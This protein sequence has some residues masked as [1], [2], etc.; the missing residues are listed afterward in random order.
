MNPFDNDEDNNVS[1]NVFSNQI[2][3]WIITTGRKSNTFVSGW[4][5]SDDQLKEHLKNIKKKNGCNGSIKD[6]LDENT[7]NTIKTLQLQG[8][9]IDF[10][11]DYLINNGVDNNTIYVKG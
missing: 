4:D 3:I 6:V 1:N 2:T 9:H 11:K 10:I 7:N 8:N 5:I